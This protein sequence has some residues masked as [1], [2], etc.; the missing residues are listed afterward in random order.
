MKWCNNEGYP[1]PTAARRETDKIKQYRTMVYICSPFAGDIEFNISRAR[2]YCR[3]AVSKG[4]IPLAP[5][6]HYPQFMDDFDKENRE[7]G[8]SFA[9]TILARCDEVWVFGGR[10]SDGMAGEIAKAKK[11]GMPIR[12]F[13]SQCKE[14]PECET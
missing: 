10:I 3:F 5:H 14:A 2:G 4:C 1:A 6:L 9:L 7:L 12:Y 11:R 13:S 8:L